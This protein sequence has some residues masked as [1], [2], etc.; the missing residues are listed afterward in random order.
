MAS[1]SLNASSSV[2]LLILGAGW[3]STFLLPHLRTHHPS[4]S[5]AA[6]TRD[7]RD[8]TIKWAWD[9]QGGSKQFEELPRAKTVVITFPIKEVGGSTAMVEGYEGVNGETRWVQLGSSGIWDVSPFSLERLAGTELMIGSREDRR[10]RTTRRRL[11]SNGLIG[12]RPT[13]PTT[14][15]RWQRTS[16]WTSDPRAS[17]STSPDSGCVLALLPLA[18]S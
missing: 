12:T 2:D 10:S 17:F 11:R 4:I 7:G 1:P 6:T 5:F 3:T 8:G 18:Q 13:L 14:L 15:V 16:F 9:P